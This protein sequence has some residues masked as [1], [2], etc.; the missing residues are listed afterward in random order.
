MNRLQS[1]QRSI[2]PECPGSGRSRPFFESALA[3]T[4]LLGAF[5]AS[6]DVDF[7]SLADSIE[8][9]P[10]IVFQS[11]MNFMHEVQDRFVCPIKLLKNIVSWCPFILLM[12]W[13]ISEVES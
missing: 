3:R 5:L 7:V 8:V 1:K 12:M 2:S 4:R 10:G 13:N 9:E 6:N 11:V